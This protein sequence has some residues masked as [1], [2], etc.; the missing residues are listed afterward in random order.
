[1]QVLNAARGCYLAIW[2]RHCVCFANLRKKYDVL[3]IYDAKTAAR[4]CKWAAVW[5]L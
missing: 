1:M 3:P 2:L 4:L 5:I